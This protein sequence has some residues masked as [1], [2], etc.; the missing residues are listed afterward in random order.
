[1]KVEHRLSLLR[2]RRGLALVVAL[3]ILVCLIP[4]A[5]GLLSLS[6]VETR[7]NA[8]LEAQAIARAN[9]RLA[10]MLAIDELQKT[11]GPDTRMS[12]R[13]ETLALD[14]RLRARVMPGSPKA[15]WVGVSSSDPE[16][17]LQQSS[18]GSVEKSISWLVSGLD[19]NATPAEQISDSNPFRRAITMY[20][21]NSINT[22]MQTGSQPIEAGLI[23]LSNGTGGFAWIIDDEGMKA[24]IAASHPDV[25]NQ[26]EKTAGRG[27]LPG[28]YD[29]SILEDMEGL[30][31]TPPDQIHKMISLNDISLL[32]GSV[33]TSRDKRLGYTTFSRGVLSDVKHGGLKKDLTMAFEQEGNDQPSSTFQAVFGNSSRGFSEKYIVM[34]PEKFQQCSDLTKHGY[35]HWEMLLD[36]YNTKKHILVRDGMEYLDSIMITKEGIFNRDNNPFKLG[37]LGPHEIGNNPSTSPFHFEMPYGNYSPIPPGS[38]GKKRDGSPSKTEYYKHSP[39]IAIL[40]RMQQNAW[41][42][43]SG[44]SNNQKLRTNVQLWHAQYNPYNI[45]INVIGDGRAHGPRIMHYP[46]VFF[47]HEGLKISQG[48]G[49]AMSLSRASGFSGKRQTHVPHE[50]LLGP[51]RTHVYAFRNHGAIGRDNDGLNYDDA[52]KDLTLESIYRDHQLI[53][54]T[55]GTLTFDFVLERP[56]MMH[57]AN[58]NSGNASHEVTQ[59]MWAPFGWEAI[60]GKPGK[61]IQKADVSTSELNQNTMASFSFRL[62][63]AREPA[64]AGSP[65]IRPL[66][67]ANIRA[68]MCNTRW[69]SPLNLPLLAAYSADDEGVVEEQIMQMDTRDAPKGYAYWGAGRDPVDGYDRVILFDIPREDLV[70]L[71]QL[72]HANIGRFSYEPTYIVGNSYANPRIPRDQWR[73]SITDTFSSSDRGLAGWKI[74][75]N[76]YLY[77]ASYLV[78]EVLWDSYIFTTIPQFADNRDAS[79][80]LQPT[81]STFQALRE[82]RLLL[83]N[84][85]FIPYEPAGSSF[86]RAT[87][88]MTTNDPE[89]TGAFHH[90]AG[91]LMVDGSFNVNSTSA[92]AWEAFLSGTHRLPYQK[93]DSNGRITGFERSVEGVRFP[94]VLASLG[95]PMKKSALDENFW[96]G[97]RDL[98]KNEVRYLAEAIV[99]EIKKRGPFLNMGQFIN[100]ALE[101]N[102]HGDRGVLQAALDKT[103]NSNLDPNFGEQAT[104]PNVANGS[105]QGSGFPGQILQGD[106][107]QALSPYMTV[108]SDTFTIRAYGECRSPKGNGKI[109]ARAWCEATLQRYPD[110]MMSA[111]ADKPP[112]EELINPSSPFGRRFRM[113]SF[114]WLSPEEV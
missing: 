18:P 65:A 75:G 114:R 3:L 57:G 34:E 74:P 54:A 98:N 78:N 68:M 49:N 56:S 12:A 24:Q 13:A 2:W 44:Q 71:G 17:G 5:V 53:S 60:N 69:D 27:L 96:T 9:A 111:S 80:D 33:N 103:I 51:G 113:I 47:S 91:H 70:S 99:D 105:S 93:L 28:T 43:R 36:F 20:G 31:G 45:G 19:P 21:E 46:Q 112:L 90:N 67:D 25:C 100:R 107:L 6:S 26:M 32:G 86:D 15:W 97:F 84:P 4:I 110:A 38:N 95:S 40:M 8:G 41:L 52:V 59:V 58:S 104:H 16:A 61:R 77:D 81:A 85:R 72:Q 42:S 88:S 79:T 37:T 73:A 108:R 106:I 94:R 14:R 76:F 109:L 48:N 23:D 64:S 11:L 7:S 101:N 66:V 35:I 87:L 30:A 39:P 92:D 83:P 1:M 55:P 29:I 89:R 62:R 10:L 102:E 82:G 50:V 63:T 22:Q